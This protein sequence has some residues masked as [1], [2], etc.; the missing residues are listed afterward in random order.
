[1]TGSFGDR[2]GDRSVT[3]VWLAIVIERIARWLPS[4]DEAR[5]HL[6]GFS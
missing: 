1:M 3:A 5:F 4:S 2:G 6:L